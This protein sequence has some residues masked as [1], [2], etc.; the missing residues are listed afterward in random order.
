MSSSTKRSGVGKKKIRMIKK[1]SQTF[2]VIFTLNGI[3]HAN[4]CFAVVGNCPH[5]ERLCSNF[6]SGFPEQ[7]PR[8]Y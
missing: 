3:A 7:D 5:F 4:Y 8:T 6:P 1:L 2:C